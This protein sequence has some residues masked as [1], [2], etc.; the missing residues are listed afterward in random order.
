MPEIYNGERSLFNK[1]LGNF[2]YIPT[3][4]I[5]LY[6]FITSFKKVKIEWADGLG[7]VF[8]LNT[9]SLAAVD[10]GKETTFAW[11]AV[12]LAA[13]RAALLGILGIGPSARICQP[14]LFSP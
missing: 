9:E 14:P 8:N 7:L 6:L 2:I 13:P 3:Q 1:V 11:Q 5:K 12:L 4:R 10:Y